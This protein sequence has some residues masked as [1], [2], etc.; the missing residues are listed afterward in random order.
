MREEGMR[1]KHSVKGKLGEA[2][3]QGVHGGRQ[4][5]AAETSIHHGGE[6]RV[7][8]RKEG[9]SKGKKI[10]ACMR[11]GVAESARSRAEISERAYGAL[12][13]CAGRCR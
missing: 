11:G 4:R 9:D 7:Y 3:R 1:V 2:V 13:G 5:V 12:S 6:F 8:R 10:V